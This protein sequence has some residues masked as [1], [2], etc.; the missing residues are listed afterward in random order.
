MN[1]SIYVSEMRYSR[2]LE[3]LGSLVAVDLNHKVS[4]AASTVHHAFTRDLVHG[5]DVLFGKG[6]GPLDSGVDIGGGNFETL[7]GPL[8]EITVEEQ[9]GVSGVLSVDGYSLSFVP[10]PVSV[11]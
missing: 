4:E 10:E 9:C 2:S 8:V 7:C 6:R 11:G 3:E 5:S 1:A